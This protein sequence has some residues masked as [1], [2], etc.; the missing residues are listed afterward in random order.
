MATAL[1][2]TALNPL[3]DFRISGIQAQRIR[4]VSTI[5]GPAISGSGDVTIDTG[6]DAHAD[7]GFLKVKG[8][9]ASAGK[10]DALQ[11]GLLLD[12]TSITDYNGAK[13]V[14]DRTT[15]KQ[16]LLGV[17][18]PPVMPAGKTF[19]TDATYGAG[20]RY[21]LEVMDANGHTRATPWNNDMQIRGAMVAASYTNGTASISQNGDFTGVKVTASSD[22]QVGGISNLTGDV[23]ISAGKLDVSGDVTASSNVTVAGNLTVNGTT[24]TVNTSTLT[25]T[26]KNIEVGAGNASDD[27]MVG[28]GLTL[29]GETDRTLNYAATVAADSAVTTKPQQLSAFLPSADLFLG[30]KAIASKHAT[31][32]SKLGSSKRS[33]AMH[34]GDI[35]ADHWIIVSKIDST[36]STNQVLQFW[37]GTDIIDDADFTSA[38]QIRAKLAFELK[39]PP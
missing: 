7:P 14:A 15:D 10:Q 38:A 20:E 16:L 29:K 2:S 5:Y 19:G 23:T 36:D 26:D 17:K 25:V 4:Q 34:F 37:Y 28:S 21:M 39:P 18:V 12:A 27:T 30:E 3:G 32:A 9:L 22:L 35:A 24:T 31:G 6:D 1:V 8:G 11:V 33:N 13:S